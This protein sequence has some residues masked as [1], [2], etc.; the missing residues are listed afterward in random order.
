VKGEGRT[1]TASEVNRTTSS[2][3]EVHKKRRRRKPASKDKPRAKMGKHLAFH[4]LSEFSDRFYPR[5]SK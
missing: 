5:G 1:R 2:D 4:P 3:A